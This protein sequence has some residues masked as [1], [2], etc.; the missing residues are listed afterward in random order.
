MDHRT[1]A[2]VDWPQP[3][4]HEEYAA[5]QGR[6]RSA[7][8]AADLSG[9]LVSSPP[10]LNYL[11]GYDQIWFAHDNLCVAFL[12]ADEETHLFFDNDGHEILV[13][14]YPEI[15]HLHLFKRG[16]V[17]DHIA[18]IAGEVAGRGWARGTIALQARCYGPH[19]DHL[20]AI[21]RLWE[22]AGARLTDG[23][24][25]I[26]DLRL[27]KSPREIAVV[28]AAAEIATAAMAAA[29][30]AI[31]E[32]MRETDLDSVLTAEL[33]KGGGGY[34]GIRNMIGAG[35]RAGVHH[36]PPS[37]RRF[38]QGDIIHIDFCSAL[39]RYHVNCCRS[40]ALG[41]VDQRWID[42]FLRNAPMMDLI[43]A[44]VKPGA[45]MQKMDEIAM[46]FAREHDLARHEWLIGGYTLGIAM[47]P[48]WVGRHRPRPREAIP[49]PK[50]EPGVIMNFENQYDCYRQGWESA[51]G[52][53]LI[54]T[55]LMTE[56]GFEILTPL[57]RELVQVG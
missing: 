41:E 38:R 34:P 11:F 23:S 30:D 46:A 24:D 27:K 8:K 35:P 5:R 18:E 2:Q 4:P 13:S 17:R 31:R 37:H 12:P 26:E 32:G 39:H 44:E 50:L 45:S 21:G 55:L 47:P 36:E 19:P 40:F 15:E 48:D 42:L 10:D 14:V 57:P 3:F 54:D 56:N 51:P 16:P 33:L 49:P 52:A 7:L 43:V 53:G 25:L 29:R 28:R 1:R 9:V 22:E 6:L 20:R